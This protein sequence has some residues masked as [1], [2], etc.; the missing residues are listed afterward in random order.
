VWRVGFWL[1]GR[2]GKPAGKPL[3]PKLTTAETA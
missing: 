2:R 1:N 3:E